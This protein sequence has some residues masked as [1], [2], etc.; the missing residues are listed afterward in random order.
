METTAVYWE[1]KIKTYGFLIERELSLLTIKSDTSGQTLWGDLMENPVVSGMKFNLVFG[2]VHESNILTLYLALSSLSANLLLDLIKHG[3]VKYDKNSYR[4][5]S[6]IE[7]LSFQG[8]HYGDR[9]GIAFTLFDTLKSSDIPLIASCFSVSCIYLLLKGGTGD[10]VR[11]ILLRNFE[12]PL[13]KLHRKD[14]K[15]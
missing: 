4:L 2:Q 11:D 14:L 3:S 6:P 8:P 12:I 13:K 1:S 15:R 10:E 9:Y 7:I 5:Q